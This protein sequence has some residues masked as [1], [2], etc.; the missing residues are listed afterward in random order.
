MHNVECIAYILHTEKT[1]WVVPFQ[2]YSK[3]FCGEPL[4][5]WLR[6]CDLHFT[7]DAHMMKR[8]LL[9]TLN[10]PLIYFMNMFVF[11]Q[12]LSTALCCERGSASSL[13]LTASPHCTPPS[14]VLW[15]QRTEI[16]SGRGRRTLSIRKYLEVSRSPRILKPVSHVLRSPGPRDWKR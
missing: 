5:I 10:G 14:V 12:V 1:V 2:T 15:C 7:W 3:V 6:I 16:A 8:F 13:L 11:V 4:H 9:V